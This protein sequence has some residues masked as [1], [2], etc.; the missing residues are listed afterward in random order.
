MAREMPVIF[1]Y[2]GGVFDIVLVFIV[3]TKKP[4]AGLFLQ[5]PFGLLSIS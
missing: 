2:G 1:E 3:P 5:L 4:L